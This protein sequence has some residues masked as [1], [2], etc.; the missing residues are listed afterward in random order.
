MNTTIHKQINGSEVQARPVFKG[1]SAPAYWAAIVD[2]HM[3]NR[4]FAS[5]RTLFQF[6]AN[7]P[8]Y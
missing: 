6:F 4:T 2:G 5:P 3:M 1:G 7:H 8:A